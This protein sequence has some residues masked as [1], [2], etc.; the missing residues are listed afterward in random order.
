[1]KAVFMR[2]SLAGALLCALLIASTYAVAQPVPAPSRGQLLYSNHCIACH[3]TQMHWRDGRLAYDWGSLTMQV[4]R[5]QGHAGLQ[6]GDA[7]V[8]EVTRYLNG[9][10]YHFPEL[11]SSAGPG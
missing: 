9:T 10:I 2:Q 1:M 7:D 11:G 3:T 5:W 8:L 6:W 4:R